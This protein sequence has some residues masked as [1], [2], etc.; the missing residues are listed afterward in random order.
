MKPLEPELTKILVGQFL[1][2]AAVSLLM[3]VSHGEQFAI[4]GFYGGLAAMVL[5][6]QLGSSVQRL[7]Q[8]LRNKETVQSAVLALGFAPRLLLV[9]ALFL[10]GIMQFGLHP[11]AMAIAFSA[12]YVVQWVSLYRARQ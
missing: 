7:D 2:T 3:L 8:R 1:I 6:W 10:L 4:S 12:T 9:L 5:S 11:L